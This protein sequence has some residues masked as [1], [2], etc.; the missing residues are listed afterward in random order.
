MNKVAYMAKG[1]EIASRLNL[2]DLKRQML[3]QKQEG[4]LCPSLRALRRV[5]S[6]LGHKVGGLG[7]LTALIF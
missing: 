7:L 2:L 6:F 4:Q 5:S 1:K 3:D